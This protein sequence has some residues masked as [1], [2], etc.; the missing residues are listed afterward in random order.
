[1][2]RLVK[3]TGLILI[4][5]G[6]SMPFSTSQAQFKEQ[7]SEDYKA[8][9]NNME[10]QYLKPYDRTANNVFE[11]PMKTDIEYEGFK[12]QWGASFRQQWQ[13]LTQENDIT[14]PDS[15]A[16]LPELG[17][18]FNTANANLYLDAQVADGMLVHVFT[19][20]SS[21]H[22][23]E[24]WVKG[25]FLQIDKFAMIDMPL[26]NALMKNLRIKFGHYEVNYGDQHYRR[27]DNALTSYNPFMGNLIMDP[28]T[29]EIGAEFQYIYNGFLATA[30]LTGGEIAGDVTDEE[31]RA[32][33]WIGKVGYDNMYTKNYKEGDLRY[34]LTGS[35]YATEK[36]NFNTLYFGDRAG[37]HYFG[38]IDPN[39]DG[40]GENDFSGRFNPGLHDEV[41]SFMINPYF[42]YKAFELFGTIE[43]TSGTGF[44]QAFNGER[45]IQQYAVE[46]V[47]YLFR[48]QNVYVGA[49]WNKV[50]AE[51]AF[52]N[53]DVEISRIQLA[54]GWFITNNIH[55]KLEYV[56]QDYDGFAPGTEF[57]G[58][59]FD[60]LVMEGSISW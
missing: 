48:D 41:T 25:G 42:K 44:D 7:Q 9:G 33:S 59:E 18:G 45:D 46:G 10:I 22:H 8:F 3:I 38:V 30:Q 51:N 1:M 32:I 35:I 57:E 29:T 23:R 21:R 58:A 36:S 47:Y 12:L 24:A 31:T 14:D 27:S 49:R 19:Y 39:L 5:L 55:L 53:R 28:F 6:F 43:T 60:G 56:D 13:T 34:R 52:T 17:P 40:S 26:L 50:D 37:S 4:V 16:Y 11:M 54:G 20:L 2:R 15:D